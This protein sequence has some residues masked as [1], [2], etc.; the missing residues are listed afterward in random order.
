MKRKRDVSITYFR[1]DESWMGRWPF[2]YAL[3]HQKKVKPCNDS[4]RGGKRK[5]KGKKK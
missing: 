1:E 4:G 5:P 2:W 3:F